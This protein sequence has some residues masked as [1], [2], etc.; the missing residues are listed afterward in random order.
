MKHTRGIVFQTLLIV[1]S[2]EEG[3]YDLMADTSCWMNKKSIYLK[4][5]GT[6]DV[7]CV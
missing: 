4:F 6:W 5:G 2:Y 3:L 7:T 1:T